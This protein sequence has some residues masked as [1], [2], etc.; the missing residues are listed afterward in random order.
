MKTEKASQ[1][2]TLYNITDFFS[3]NYGQN[4]DF[5]VYYVQGESYAVK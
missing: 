2:R 5:S 1:I 3:K 4:N